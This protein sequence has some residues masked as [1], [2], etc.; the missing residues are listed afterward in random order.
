MKNLIS[1]K[2]TRNIALVGI[3]K[4]SGKTTLLNAILADFPKLKW[5]VMST[6]IDGE[7]KDRLY[8]TPK[9]QV[10][11]PK[12]I[13]YCCDAQTLDQQGSKIELLSAVSYQG[14][15][16]FLARTL[17]A[18]Q[19]Q[20]TGPASVLQQNKMIAHFRALGAKKVLI[21]GAL[22]RKSIALE[23]SI[24]ALIL[25]IG[26]SFGSI[27]EIQRE[28]KRLL[29]LRDLPSADLSNYQM[30]RLKRADQI[31]VYSQKRWR[32]SGIKS[33][34]KHENQLL[35]LLN[36]KTKALYI[37]TAFTDILYDRLAG[38]FLQRDLTLIFRHPE[39]LKLSWDKLERFV[40]QNRVSA[41]IPFKIKA[42]A[43]NSTA[44]GKAPIAAD[45]FRE[46]IR[47]GF[48]NETFFDLMEI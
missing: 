2:A 12:G 32:Q 19:T 10:L 35:G 47:A 11:L 27:S 43:L 41:L 7:E 48:P 14:R 17:A 13:M 8:K 39:C 42:F 21:D 1:A 6:G 25:C 29:L 24:D 40:D 15:K 33:L 26:A 45:E 30:R 31:L 22:D 5:A 9:P 18:I 16:L 36:H 46:Q 38:A 23:D 4:N 20:I 37:P 3:S 28:L 34:I 44:I